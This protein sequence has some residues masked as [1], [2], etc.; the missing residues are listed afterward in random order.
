MSEAPL[1]P[2]EVGHGVNFLAR[3]LKQ[4]LN[5][6]TFVE[7]DYGNEF[8]FV[9]SADNRRVSCVISRSEAGRL[10]KALERCKV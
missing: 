5:T 9:V 7:H 4:P 2:E 6:I 10:M 3:C 1:S 8:R